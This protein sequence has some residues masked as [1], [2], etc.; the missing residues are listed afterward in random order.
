MSEDAMVVGFKRVAFPTRRD[1]CEFMGREALGLS[2]LESSRA[3][4]AMAKSLLELGDKE[5]PKFRDLALAIR[6]ATIRATMQS[7][8]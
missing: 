1:F 8:D 2:T 5:I 3:W 4:R 7:D 6:T